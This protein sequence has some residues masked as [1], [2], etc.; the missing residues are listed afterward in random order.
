VRQLTLKLAV[1]LTIISFALFTKW[2]YALP[3]DAPDTMYCG[4]PFVYVGHG[5]GSSMTL[6][7]FLIEFI[8]DLLIYFVFWFLIITCI[9]Y[10]II[11]IRP[12]KALTI[13]LWSLSAI[14]I[15]F[16][17]LIWSNNDNTFYM[18]REY[19]FEVLTT[20]YQFMWDNVQRP[21]YNKYR[22]HKKN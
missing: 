2:W 18:K 5:W 3:V 11:K 9:N 14:I 20:G 4:F 17:A 22:T 12:Y 21:D 6:Q 1:P 8:S 10:Y 16:N 19:K 15:G 13:L 7:I